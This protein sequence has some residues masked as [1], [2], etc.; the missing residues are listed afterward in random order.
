MKIL[1]SMLF[2]PGDSE[3]KLAKAASTPADALILD[4]EDAVSVERIGVARGM[5]CDYLQQQA[6]GQQ[7]IWVRINPLSTDLALKDLTA[8]MPGRPDGIVLP[9]TLNAND[10]VM[11]DH[12]LSAL[13]TRE[14]LTLGS[15]RIIP[16]ATEV[17][18]ALFELQSYAGASPRLTGLTWGAEDLA[19]AVGASTNK[20]EHGEFEF[21][22]QLA[23]SMCLL[24]ASHAQVQAIDTLTVDF[25]DGDRLRKD[26]L[27]ARRSGFTGKLAIHPDQVLPIHAGFAPDTHEVAHAQRIVDAFAQAAGAG[28]VQLD[29]KMVDKPHLTQALRLLQLA[30]KD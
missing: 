30:Q 13:E 4:L 24:A 18:G 21:T 5:V 28:A 23:R 22:F 27:R 11:L 6:R 25:R 16:V 29:G 12:F 19:T 8:V 15:T 3:K 9:K 10:V 7:E 17:A 1:R 20:D 14:G 2:V 26:V